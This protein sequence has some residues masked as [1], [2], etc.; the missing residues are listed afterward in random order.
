[1][2]RL[3]VELLRMFLR[4]RGGDF[5][6]HTVAGNDDGPGW[7]RGEGD[8]RQWLIRPP[9]FR[10]IFEPHELDPVECA[11]MFRSAGILIGQDSG[12]SL[13]GV[14]Q[15]GRPSRSVRA[16]V[17]DAAALAAWRPTTGEAYKGYRGAGAGQYGRDFEPKT[18][19][20]AMP[21]G[22]GGS[23]PADLAAKLETVVGLALDEALSVLQTRVGMADKSY[24]AVL[25]AKSSL[26]NTFVNAQVRVDEAKL[27]AQQ[28]DD[29]R[30]RIMH[31]IA[32]EREKIKII[33]AQAARSISPPAKL[34][35]AE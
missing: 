23:A 26:I 9:V 31:I 17:I 4:L 24:Q 15:V 20:I 12:D 6:P 27:K 1:M 7:I 8:N 14:V 13:Q 5:G 21:S 35:E 34:G 10:Q 22:P 33:E 30:E 19:L 32:E 18:A 3:T 2:E 28:A 16:Y 11:R 29:R 25:R